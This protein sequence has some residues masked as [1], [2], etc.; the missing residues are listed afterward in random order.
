MLRR[1]HRWIGVAL[2]GWLVLVSLSGVLLL[3]ENEYYGWRYPSLPSQPYA[4][5]LKP[6]VI[7]QIL[8]SANGQV[9]SM[10]LPTPSLPAYRAYLT[11]G[12]E[13]MFHP[14]TAALVAEW[15]ALDA[16]PAFLFEL[17]AHLLLG[18]IG[19]D[20]GGVLGVFLFLNIVFGLVL[21]SRRR[22]VLQ[23]RYFLPKGLSR[24][25][26]VRG[27]A[28]QG[29]SLAVLFLLVAFTGLA[30]AFSA[31]VSAGL[32]KIFGAAEVIRPTVRH[33]DSES[34][35]I[36]WQNALVSV[37]SEFPA[38]RPS[39]LGIPNATNEPLIVRLRNA[40]ELHPNGRSYL[41]LNPD[42]GEV[43]ERIDATKTGLGPTIG[44]LLYPLHAGKTGWPGYRL[45]LSV[46]S[47]SLLFVGTS[48]TYL[49]LTRP[50]ARSTDGLQLER[51]GRELS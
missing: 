15:G 8:S 51:P 39:L 26:L 11:D 35:L 21:W 12:S 41:V 3:W 36:N 18:D 16:L 13:A 24:P 47:L 5:V 45:L 33:V 30:M 32:N 49:A 20:I 7:E 27:H 28:A 29:V 37:S 44:N 42:N 46:L 31:P 9:G 14:E 4:P 2:A 19:T 10:L 48:G 23:I 50:R 1:V 17:H 22:K 25:L 38:A 40:G 6:A 43:L 34:A